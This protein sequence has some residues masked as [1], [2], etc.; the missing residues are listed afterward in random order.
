MLVLFLCL[1]VN[2]ERV[3][4]QLQRPLMTADKKRAGVVA[5]AIVRDEI[6]DCLGI[7]DIPELL[8]YDVCD[9]DLCVS[10]ESVEVEPPYPV[11]FA[12]LD[13]ALGHVILPKNNSAVGMRLVVDN[14]VVPMATSVICGLELSSTG[15]VTRLDL[16]SLLLS[17]R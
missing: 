6:I 1:V 17:E 8:L 11:V 16:R 5:I 7:G 13:E 4:N 12:R 10:D 3:L 9:L 2:C 15:V 14:E